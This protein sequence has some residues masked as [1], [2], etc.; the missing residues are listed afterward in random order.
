MPFSRGSPWPGDGTHVSYV[1]CPGRQVLY[2]NSFVVVVS[3][4]VVSDS[5]PPRGQQY[6]R[7]RCP[8]PSPEACSNSCPLN[9]WCHPTISSSVGRPLLLLPSIFPSISIFSN[10]SALCIRWPKYW[11][12][13]ISPSNEYSRDR[14]VWSPCSPRD[15]QEPS[16]TPRVKNNKFF[17]PTFLYG[18]TLTSIHVYWK[19]HSFDY[20]DLLNSFRK[21][22]LQVLVKNGRIIKPMADDKF[23]I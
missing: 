11:S 17:G 21:A 10:E 20:T 5:L 8:S 22:L 23:N 2:H 12:F 14:L 3:R 16:P 6:P 7:L 15:S 13:S 19:N 4:S 18:P 1:S 9:Q